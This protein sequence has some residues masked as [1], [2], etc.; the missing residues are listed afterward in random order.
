[1]SQSIPVH[2]LPNGKYIYQEVAGNYSHQHPTNSSWCEQHTSVEE[3]L[4]CFNKQAAEQ[5]K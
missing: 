5:K 1:M 3:A 4:A 2:E